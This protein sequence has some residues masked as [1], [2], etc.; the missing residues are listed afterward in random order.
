MRCAMAG[1]GWSIEAAIALKRG[2]RAQRYI[3]ERRILEHGILKH[4]TFEHRTFELRF[5]LS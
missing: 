2:D 3:V 1:C 5:G 4:R